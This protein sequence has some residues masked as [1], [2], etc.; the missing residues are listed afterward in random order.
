MLKSSSLR[1]Q[2]TSGPYCGR[3]SNYLDFPRLSWSMPKAFLCQRATLD[4]ERGMGSDCPNNCNG[5]RRPDSYFVPPSVFDPNSPVC[6]PCRRPPFIDP[7]A[8]PV[9]AATSIAALPTMEFPLPVPPTSQASNP[10]F[11]QPLVRDITRTS[12]VLITSSCRVTLGEVT[13]E[14]FNLRYLLRIHSL[15]T[16]GWNRATAPQLIPVVAEDLYD[17]AHTVCTNVGNLVTLILDEYERLRALVGGLEWQNTE[18]KRMLSAN[19]RNLL[20]NGGK[21]PPGGG[22]LRPGRTEPP[23]ERID[24][25]PGE[26]EPPLRA[27]EPHNL[28]TLQVRPI[29]KLAVPKRTSSPPHGMGPS[30]RADFSP[31]YPQPPVALR[32]SRPQATIGTPC[33]TTTSESLGKRKR[34]AEKY[35]YQSR[36]RKHG[37]ARAVSRFCTPFLT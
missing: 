3:V 9:S 16:V 32:M 27:V 24:L 26:W 30:N 28:L 8:I 1:G 22:K 23:S 5:F 37:N 18:L 2:T 17:G 15:S 33:Q 20:P 35:P 12:A 7:A 21:P 6:N 34:Q 10:P 13:L 4:G 19:V 29:R 36:E 25:S 14:V 31:I 11:V